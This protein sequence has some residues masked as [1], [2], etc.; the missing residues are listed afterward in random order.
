M[1]TKLAIDWPMSTAPFTS[2]GP[3]AKLLKSIAMAFVVMP[4]VSVVS[5]I[6]WFKMTAK[7]GSLKIVSSMEGVPENVNVCPAI[8]R[9][10]PVIVVEPV[11]EG[12]GVPFTEDVELIVAALTLKSAPPRGAKRKL[13]A[14][15]VA[16]PVSVG[17]KDELAVSVTRLDDRPS[18]GK[19]RECEFVTSYGG[20]ADPAA[21]DTGPSV[22]EITPAT[23]SVTSRTVDELEMVVTAAL[24]GDTANVGPHPV[25]NAKAPMAVKADVL[26]V[27]IR[28]PACE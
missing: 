23:L 10:S 18:R 2:L 27:M 22:I 24:A 13:L 9:L 12:V 28:S 3:I 4:A 5:G 14:V 26:S 20:G 8:V 25:D 11:A 19:L 21:G 17:G 1:T 6:C 15:D 7:P 16:V